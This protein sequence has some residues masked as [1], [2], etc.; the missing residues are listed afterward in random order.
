MQCTRCR[1]L[2]VPEIMQDGGMRVVAYRCIHCGDVI[3][4]KILQHRAQPSA[5]VLK[6]PRTPIFGHGR[7]ERRDSSLVS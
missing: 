4:N 7:W 1:G 6:R 2:R 3:D 5:P